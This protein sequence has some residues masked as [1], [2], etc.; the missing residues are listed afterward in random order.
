MNLRLH[1]SR[2]VPIAGRV[3]LDDNVP[4]PKGHVGPVEASVRIGAGEMGRA[5]DPE[6]SGRLVAGLIVKAAGELRCLSSRESCNL[7]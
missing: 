5:G 1:G 3:T 4:S 6:E 2:A 7:T